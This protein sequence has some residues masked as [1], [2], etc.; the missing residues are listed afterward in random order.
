MKNQVAIGI[1]PFGQE[2][3]QD[4]SKVDLDTLEWPLGKPA[5]LTGGKTSK[6]LSKDHLVVFPGSRVW[7]SLRGPLKAG[8]TLAI[9][10]PRSF[11]RQHMILARLFHNRFKYILTSDPDL[12]KSIPNGIE[13]PFGTSWV[14]DWQSLPLKKTRNLSLIASKKK[15]LKGHKLRHKCATWL[16]NE[17]IDADIMGRGYQPFDVKSDGLA[18]Y[19]YS[20]VIENCQEQNYFTEKLVDAFLCKTVPIYWGCPNIGDYFDTSGMIICNSISDIQN[21]VQ[22][23]SDRDYNSR[24]S[25]MTTNQEKAV[26]YG[27]YYGRL[28][29]AVLNMG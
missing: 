5:R 4:L 1:L 17:K 14:P 15:R 25:Q 20:V 9:T 3:T 19:R 24:S 7:S 26:Y 13:V 12:L 18:P 28:A 29:K 11:H 6:M 16:K 27:D 8:L 22:G 21:A 23:I 10:E 2:I